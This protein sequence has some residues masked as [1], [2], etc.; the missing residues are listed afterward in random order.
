MRRFVILIVILLIP[1]IPLS[2]YIF[3]VIRPAVRAPTPVS[4]T[5]W[6]TT[7]DAKT[8]EPLLAEYN[9]LRPYITIKVERVPTDDYASRLKD[10]WARGRGPD[11]FELPASWIGEFAAD[12]LAPVPAQTNVFNYVSKKILFR[13]DTEIKQAT[14]P[15]VT[16]PQLQ[17]DFADVVAEDVVRDGKIY[18]LPLWLDTLVLYYN[19]DILRSANLVEPPK[20]WQQLTNIVP[21]LTIADE[22]GKLLQSAVPLGRGRNVR[23][24]ADIVSLLFLQDGVL[25]EGEN[26]NVHLDDSKSTDGTNLGENALAF[27][28]SF[29]N[30]GK[31]VYSWNADQPNSLE[32]FIRG[33]SALFLGY[34]A[35]R[36]AIAAG[37]SID[38]GVAPMLHLQADG[39]D[40]LLTPAGNALQVN[41]GNYRVLSVFQRS[42]HVN[43]AWNF[44]QYITKQDAVALKYLNATKRVGALRS[45]LAKQVGDPVL[46]VQAEQAISARSWYRG[47]NAT[48]TE[49]HLMDM[50]DS[51]ASGQA[52]PLQ[53]LTLARK[54]I[55]LT[56]KKQP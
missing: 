21:K 3:G 5:Y 42:K 39:K 11:M 26:G 45:I 36:A 38:F 32:A 31:A 56:T 44:V 53:A 17:R 50:I 34:E 16:V 28:V 48:L 30:Q 37:S 12:F 49:Q 20:T 14:V 46:G 24:A 15:S 6:T 54:Q 8:L 52:A 51:V 33:R 25:L 4:L 22:E 7:D 27:L 18:G 55:E 1:I 29:A 43:E 13:T 35:D 19:R 23:H 10:A 9:A 41:Y 40:A 2:L 47:R